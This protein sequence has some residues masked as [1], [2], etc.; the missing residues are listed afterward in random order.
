MHA[1]RHA[2]N[3]RQPLKHSCPKP[4]SWRVAKGEITPRS[5]EESAVGGVHRVESMAQSSPSTVHYQPSTFRH[6]TAAKR[7]AEHVP[8]KHAEV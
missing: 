6:P 2:V 5:L 7:S 1:R 8:P 4:P 3:A